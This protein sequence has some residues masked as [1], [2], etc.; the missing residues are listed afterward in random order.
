[1]LTYNQQ[2]LSLTSTHQYDILNFK[3]KQQQ[4]K[5]RHFQIQAVVYLTAKSGKNTL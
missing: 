4:Q 3:P 1:M 5:I 2:P